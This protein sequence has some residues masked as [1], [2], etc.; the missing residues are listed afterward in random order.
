MQTGNTTPATL[1]ATLASWRQERKLSMAAVAKRCGRNEATISRYLAGTM[2]GDVDGLERSL[3]DMMDA[4]ARRQTWAEIYIETQGCT[5]TETVLDLI[6]GACDIG[7]IT[8]AAGLGKT[9]AC[10]RYAATRDSSILITLSEGCGSNWSIIRLIFDRLEMRGWSRRTGGQ[11]RGEAAA[12][13]LAGSE[14]LLI[15]DN[16]QRATLSGLRWLFDLSDSAGIPIALVGNPDVLTRVAGSD[17]L[18]SRIGLR[19]DIGSRRDMAWLDEASES[20]LN[21]MWPDAP[22]EV[23]LLAQEAARQPGH[24]RRLVKQLRIAIRLSESA[25]WRRSAAAAFVEARTLIGVETEM[26]VHT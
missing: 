5:E 17:Q 8:G 1:R 25:S 3:R 9:T 6:R 26:E 18:S 15:V 20:I 4:D 21:A 10:R 11:T 23:R 2:T 7:L 19:A 16:A 12:S 14:R 22:A 13:R 24:L